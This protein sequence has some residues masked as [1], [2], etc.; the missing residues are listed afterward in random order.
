MEK[1]TE[2]NLVQ[3]LA[4]ISG[5]VSVPKKKQPDDK[6]AFRRLDD[7]IEAINPLLSAAGIVVETQILSSSVER[8]TETVTYNNKES[9]RFIFLATTKRRYTFT[10]GKDK[11]VTEEEAGARDYGDKAETQAGSNCLKYMYI[12][13]FN[14]KSGEEEKEGKEQ[15][16][17]ETKKD[18]RPFI[19]EAAFQKAI[20]RLQSGEVGLLPKLEE[21]FRFS[22]N[23]EAAIK[24]I[25][26][27]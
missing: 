18:R 5:V 9:E 13:F 26:Q 21:T 4:E 25:L 6:Y 2:K 24:K 11:V 22:K 17:V 19:T 27:K 8:L 7:V 16:P 12:R 3:K 20:A 15:R 14:M 1:S 10:D 23:Q